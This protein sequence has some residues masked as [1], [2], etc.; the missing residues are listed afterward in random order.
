MTTR[1][2]EGAQLL[3]FKLLDHVIVTDMELYSS[4]EEGTL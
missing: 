4:S 3:G 2:K 1:L